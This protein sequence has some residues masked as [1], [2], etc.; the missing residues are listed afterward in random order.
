ML[1]PLTLRWL[2]APLA[3]SRYCTLNSLLVVRPDAAHRQAGQCRPCS[4]KSF[5]V[6]LYECSVQ[7]LSPAAN[8]I[9]GPSMRTTCRR[10]LTRCISIRLSPLVE[11]GAM[12]ELIEVEVGPEFAVDATSRFLLNAAVTPAASS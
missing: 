1:I 5:S 4:R 8:Q 3:T 11:H 9:D 7:M 10:L 2:T 12:I 6:Y